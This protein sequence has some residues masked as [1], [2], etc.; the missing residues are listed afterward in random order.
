MRALDRIY[1]PHGVGLSAGDRAPLRGVLLGA[2]LSF[3]P[4]PPVLDVLSSAVAVSRLPEYQPPRDTLGARLNAVLGTLGWTSHER[5][6]Q[7]KWHAQAV[8]AM[9]M[10][11]LVPA[12]ARELEASGWLR[13]HQTAGRLRVGAITHPYDVLEAFKTVTKLPASLGRE[14]R[15]LELVLGLLLRGYQ[16]ALSQAGNARFSFEAEAKEHFI[17]GAR[18]ERSLKHCTDSNDRLGVLQHV[19]NAYYH[20]KNYY[21]FSVIARQNSTSDGKMFVMFCHAALSLAQIDWDG[22]LHTQPVTARLP[23][24][25]EVTFLFSRDRSLRERCARDSSLFAQTKALI[26]TFPTSA[27]KSA[28]PG[29]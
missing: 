27:T 23:P 29:A 25:A 4:S 26:S 1:S 7:L 8:T 19:I 16:E 11:S 2:S 20:A 24:R 10:A 15:F 17:R 9:V 6:A 28:G 5:E 22:T 13:R 14:R 21:M 12:V 18:L 3:E